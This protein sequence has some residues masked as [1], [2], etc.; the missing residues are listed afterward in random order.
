MIDVGQCLSTSLKPLAVLCCYVYRQD[1]NGVKCLNSTCTHL[2]Y[3]IVCRLCLTTPFLL[4]PS[5]LCV[6]CSACF[7]PAAC[8]YLQVLLLSFSL[9]ISSNL[10]PE[11]YSQLSQREYT[12]TKG[13]QTHTLILSLEHTHKP[14]LTPLHR[15]TPQ[16]RRAP[17]SRWMKCEMSL[18][19]LSALSPGDLRT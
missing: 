7:C 15:V 1:F 8:V 18:L 3:K 10:Q 9:L 12:Q 6:L 5:G 13:L 17:C 11:P 19:F 2:L 4:S 16:C 14:T